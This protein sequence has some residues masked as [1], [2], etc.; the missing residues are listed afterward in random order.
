MGDGIDLTNNRGPLLNI[1]EWVSLTAVIFAAATKF[2][3]KW[4]MVKNLDL[5]DIIIGVAV[6]R[7][8]LLLL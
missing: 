8:F 6:V 7:F 5:N 2:Y 4:K 3:V 1:A